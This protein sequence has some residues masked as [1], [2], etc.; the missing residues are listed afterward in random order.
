VEGGLTQTLEIAGQ[1]GYRRTAAEQELAALRET[2]EEAR[3]QLRAEVEQK[4]VRVV[5]LQL[6]AE[7]E[8]GLVDLIKDNSAVT[9]K[10]FDAGEDTKLDANLAEVELGRASNQ[11]EIVAEQLIQAR[12]DLATLLQL[13]AEKL[14][15]VKGRLPSK[16][17]LPYTVDQL[18]AAAASRAQLRALDYREQAARNRLGLERA[19]VYPDVT[20]G[21]SS[22]R[23]GPGD[24]REKLV[25]L[26]VSIPL[27]FFR[28]NAAGIGKASAE[29]TQ[30][31]IEKQAAGRDTRARVLAL[32][33]KLDSLRQR[34]RRMDQ[35]VLQRLEENQRLSTAAYRAGE[36][37]L[38]QMLLATRQVLDT[39]R[40]VLEAMTD[41]ALTRSELEQSAGWTGTK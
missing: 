13:P 31:E 9:R 34:V 4:F 40:E 5:S 33:Q 37:S 2:I 30:A 32:W 26:S 25:G 22:A 41:F 6:R 21:L 38:V 12:A 39:R 24:A 36:I 7:M 15:T 19:A 16:P 23:E 3:R 28:R 17:E 11:L 18:L 10:R 20:V 35:S 27:P 14:P 29:L 8:T 1:Q